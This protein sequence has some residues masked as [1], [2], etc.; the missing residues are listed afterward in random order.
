MLQLA[1]IEE[2]K[3]D[4]LNLKLKVKQAEVNLALKGNEF[5]QLSEKVRLLETKSQDDSVFEHKAIEIFKYAL[6]KEDSEA[7]I[8]WYMLGTYDQHVKF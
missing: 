1:E 3:T 2:I 8:K 5:V 7:D 4:N 6:F